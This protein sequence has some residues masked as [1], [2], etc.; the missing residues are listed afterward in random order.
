MLTR[1]VVDKKIPT[2]TKYDRDMFGLK[3]PRSWICK[4]PDPISVIIHPGCFIKVHVF[5]KIMDRTIYLIK[6]LNLFRVIDIKIN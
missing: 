3:A 4:T 1:H 5:A 6:F 2:T